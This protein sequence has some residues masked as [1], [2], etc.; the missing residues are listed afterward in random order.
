M[1]SLLI[2]TLLLSSSANAGWFRNFCERHLV[3]TVDADSEEFIDATVD[4][5]VRL[6][7]QY[8]SPGAYNQALLMIKFGDLDRDDLEVLTKAVVRYQY[9]HPR[10]TK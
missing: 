5:L 7:D 4:M 1:K 2:A 10:G 8:G 6:M 3:L 9:K